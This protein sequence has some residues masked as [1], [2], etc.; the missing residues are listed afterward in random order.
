Y[1]RSRNYNTLFICGT[2]EYGTATKQ[3][4]K[5]KESRV[6]NFVTHAK[7]YKWFDIEFDYFGRNTTQQQL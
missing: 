2:D 1:S 4:L 3:K 5:K 7:I 6:K